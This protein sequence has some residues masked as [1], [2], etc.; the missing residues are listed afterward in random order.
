M[1]EWAAVIQ[2]ST[3]HAGQTVSSGPR[4]ES[5]VHLSFAGAPES[6]KLDAHD[7]MRLAAVIH[8]AALQPLAHVGGH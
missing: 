7:C 6:S 4:T 1:L 5:L 8:A 2:H 3:K